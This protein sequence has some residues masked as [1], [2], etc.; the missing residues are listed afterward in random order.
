MVGF[1]AQYCTG[2]F[3]RGNQVRANTVALALWHIVHMFELAGHPEP[4]KQ[5][6]WQDLLLAFSCQLKCYRNRDPTL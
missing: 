4:R 2:H 1:A 6:G 5:T 3:G